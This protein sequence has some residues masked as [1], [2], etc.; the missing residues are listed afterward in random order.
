MQVRK[1]QEE[2]G[3]KHTMWQTSADARISALEAKLG[4]ASQP[5]QG[6]VKE[7]EGGTLKETIWGRNKENP[8]VTCQALG[9]KWKEHG[10]LVG[11]SNSDV[12]HS[13]ADS[14]NESVICTSVQ[15]V[16][17]IAHT[18]LA[19]VKTKIKL[20]SH[21]DTCVICNHCLIV[22]DLS[23]PINVYGYGP[24]AG[25]KHAHIVDAAFTDTLAETGQVVILSINEA[26]EMNGF[27][28]HPLCPMQCC[29]NGVLINEVPKFLVPI[30]S[31]IMH[32]I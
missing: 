6:G 12:S 22:H 14:E 5:E 29:M 27:D 7:K 3:I 30:P 17:L 20:D 26:V 2:Q 32:A 19:V 24:K 9:A 25:S 13:C 15:A 16:H 31:E 8:E 18:S 10:W 28:H 4:I 23:R 11:W 1:L 21:A